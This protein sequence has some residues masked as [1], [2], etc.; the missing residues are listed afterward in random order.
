M[1]IGLLGFYGANEYCDDY[2]EIAIRKVFDDISKKK[3]AGNIE[4]VRFNGN[5]NNDINR[6]L[7]DW[8]KSPLDAVI[9]GGGSILGVGYG[10]SWLKN[11]VP[12]Y[13]YGSGFREC[14]NLE[15]LKY[16]LD[17]A[18]FV[19]LRGNTCIKRLKDLG[20]N[21]SKVSCVG[22]P[23]FLCDKMNVMNAKKATDN[24][25][26]FIGG[27]FRPYIT[28]DNKIKQIFDY[29]K[30]NRKEEIKLFSFAKGQGD[31]V[32]GK[33]I[34]FK[35]MDS[36]NNIETYNEMI[37]SS[38]WFGNRLHP[39]CIALMHGISTI[40]LDIE[41]NKVE[42]VC[43]TLDYPYWIKNENLNLSTFESMYKDVIDNHEKI[44]EGVQKKIDIIRNDLKMLAE[45]IF[46]D[47]LARCKK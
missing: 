22:D 32:G 8:E 29:L 34:G 4:W 43:S 37:K 33:K 13:I 45:K 41:F 2:L 3:G 42:S 17:R 14:Q 39:F 27:V 31:D 18:L 47:I 5:I 38:F 24:G 6:K 10:I 1:K 15:D 16:M 36:F 11:N 7:I 9:L 25:N 20:L 44:N 28:E 12:F 21:V 30:V 23:I 40:G 26:S 46:D 19:S 35:T